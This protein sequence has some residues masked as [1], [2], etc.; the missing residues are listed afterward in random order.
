LTKNRKD[1]ADES[2]RVWRDVLAAVGGSGDGR[3]LNVCVEKVE[4]VE[5][6][7]EAAFFDDV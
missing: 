2:V 3:T 6:R 1:I 5:K 4:K 7:A